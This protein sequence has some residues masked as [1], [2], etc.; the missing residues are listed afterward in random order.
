M[1]TFEI[2]TLFP[3][4]FPGPLGV[5]I[6]KKSFKKSWDLKIHDL[7]KYGIGDNRQVDDSIFSGI[8]GMLIKPDVIENVMNDINF[9]GKKIF[10]SPKGSTFNQSISEEMSA[11][12]ESVLLLS[13]RYEGIDDRAIKYY[14]FEEMSIGNYILAGGEV[15]SMVIMESIIRKLPGVIGNANSFNHETF[16]DNK[17]SEPRYTRPFNWQLKNGDS[18]QVDEILIS[19]D[20]QKIKDFQNSKRR[21]IIKKEE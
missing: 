9:Q 5:S 20:H 18:M 7:R 6:F 11:S 2:I 15:A 3:E 17:I 16:Q 12:N 19:G 21:S 1:K 14:E 4:L 8:P 13:G 10:L